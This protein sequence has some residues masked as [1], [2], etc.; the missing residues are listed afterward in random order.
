ME[1]ITRTIVPRHGVA[2]GADGL[3][4]MQSALLHTTAPLALA[5]APTGA[6]KSYVYR[7]ALERG[8]R[9]LFVV[10]TRRLAQNQTEGIRADLRSGGWPERDIE[11]KSVLGRATLR[12]R[13]AHRESMSCGIGSPGCRSSASVSVARSFSSR[14]RRSRIFSLT[15]C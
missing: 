7:R 12:R 2:I 3:S 1:L 15:R 13:C 14:R 9:V 8:E 4:R 5:S 10:P 11:R 6:G